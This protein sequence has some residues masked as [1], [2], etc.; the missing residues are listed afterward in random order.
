MK[1]KNHLK[2]K[3]IKKICKDVTKAQKSSNN[4]TEQFLKSIFSKIECLYGDFVCWM[5]KG[6][7]DSIFA[8]YLRKRGPILP[9][10]KRRFFVLSDETLFYYSSQEGFF[11]FSFFFF[12]C[13][14]NLK[15]KNRI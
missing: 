4:Q 6:G 5:L 8:G 12:G 15:Y 7:R 1:M 14:F 3:R 9:V 13:Q 2:I 10:R 11:S